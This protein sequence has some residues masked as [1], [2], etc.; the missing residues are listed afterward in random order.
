M[1]KDIL[2]ALK[3]LKQIKNPS[4]ETQDVLEFLEQAIQAH[5]KQNLLDLMTVG[6]IVGYAELH[7]SLLEITKL[8]ESMKNQVK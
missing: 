7:N 6:D 2:Q 3:M 8:V 4:K 5:S 1:L